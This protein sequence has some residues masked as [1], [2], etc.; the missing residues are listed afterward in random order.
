V[1]SV[2]V[3]LHLSAD[4]ELVYQI[5]YKVVI[6]TCGVRTSEWR[7]GTGLFLGGCKIMPKAASVHIMLQQ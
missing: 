3:L 7:G 6:P 4:F 2:C 1:L 5:L